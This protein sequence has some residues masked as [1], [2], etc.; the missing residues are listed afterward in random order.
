MTDVFVTVHYSGGKKVDL[1]LP[2]EV[3]AKKLQPGIL[4][5]LGLMVIPNHRLMLAVQRGDEFRPIRETE[6]LADARV[7]VGDQLEI[8]RWR[9][10][11]LISEGG[12]Q[13]WL[14]EGQTSIGRSIPDQ[15]VDIDLSALDISQLVSRQHARIKHNH[16]QYFI[17]DHNSRNGV[18]VRGQRV[19]SGQYQ[20]LEEGDPIHFGGQQG[21]QLTFHYQLPL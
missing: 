20:L 10:A 18:L 16:N 3:P 14:G 15:P 6:T 4:A 21:I 5:A 2:W 19:P 1:S 13:F 8:Y 17:K 7:L 12:D 11:Y 9:K